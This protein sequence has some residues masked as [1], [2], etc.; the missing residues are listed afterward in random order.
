MRMMG[1]GVRVQR[2][3]AAHRAGDT[4]TR[5]R[6]SPLRLL[7]GRCTRRRLRM[8]VEAGEEER[9]EERQ[10]ERKDGEENKMLRARTPRTPV[11]KAACLISSRA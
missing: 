9:K 10:E 11:G 6:C 1:R 4:T 7:V 8:G 5:R 2:K 3:S